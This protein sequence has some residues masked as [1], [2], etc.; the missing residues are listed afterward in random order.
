VDRLTV[1]GFD[2]ALAR[3]IKEAAK[4]HGVSLNR[5]ALMLLR[6]GAGLDT[7]GRRSHRVGSS[8]NKLVGAWTRSEAAEF[9]QPVRAMEKHDTDFWK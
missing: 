4:T 5:A 1:R 6:R 3:C 9:M 7:S 2:K 8:L